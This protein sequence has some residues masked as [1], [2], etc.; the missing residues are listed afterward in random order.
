VA[1]YGPAEAERTGCCYFYFHPEKVTKVRL[2]KL[3]F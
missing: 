2:E 3:K 1:D